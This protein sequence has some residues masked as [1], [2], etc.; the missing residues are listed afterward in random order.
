[1]GWDIGVKTWL[2]VG[3]LTFLLSSPSYG[4]AIAE[5]VGVDKGSVQE[6]G[7]VDAEEFCATGIGCWNRT[8]RKPTLQ[9]KAPKLIKAQLDEFEKKPS[10]NEPSKKST[11]GVY[12]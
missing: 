5:D 8:P 9:E 1:M 3:S 7:S 4:E 10:A 6:A 11:Q 12:D 2:L